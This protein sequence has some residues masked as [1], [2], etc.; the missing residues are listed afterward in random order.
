MHR[1]CLEAREHFSFRKRPESKLKAEGVQL[2]G[3]TYSAAALAELRALSIAVTARSLVPTLC[4]ATSRP[5]GH[6]V[7]LDGVR[8]TGDESHVTTLDT[9]CFWEDPSRIEDILP[10]AHISAALTRMILEP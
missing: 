1:R 8:T 3:S 4:L 10:D 5:A 6:A 2:L 7:A 9:D